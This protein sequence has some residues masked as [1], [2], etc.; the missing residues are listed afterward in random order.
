MAA[1]LVNSMN[2]WPEHNPPHKQDLGTPI[3]KVKTTPYTT[4]REL[5][6]YTS[7]HS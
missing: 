1:Y 6:A 5:K 3:P 7:I 4:L 2:Y